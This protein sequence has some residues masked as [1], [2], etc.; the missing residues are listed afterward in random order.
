MSAGARGG[1]AAAWWAVARREWRMVVSSPAAWVAMA[2]FALPPGIAFAVFCVRPGAPASLRLPLQAA[3]WALFVAAPVLGMRTVVEERRAGTWDPLLAS[4]A[5]PATI[6]LGKLAALAGLVALF[7]LPLLAEFGLLSLVAAPDAAE[8]ACGLLGVMLAG[9]AI[10]ASALWMS[11]LAPSAVSAYVLTVTLWS[12]WAAA[13]RAI[14]QLLP[15]P[16]SASGFS[17]DPLRRVDDFLAGLLDLGAVAFFA[18]ATAAAAVGAVDAVRDQLRPGP[19][20][21]RLLPRTAWVAGVACALGAAAWIANAPP[22]RAQVDLT[23]TRSWT[24]SRETVEMVARLP[25]DWSVEALVGAGHVDPV[26]LRQLDEVL[27]RLDGLP[28][29]D[30]VLRARRIDPTDPAGAADFERSLE[31]AEAADGEPLTRARRETDAGLKSLQAL[32]AFSRREVGAVTLALGS[33]PAGGADPAPGGWTPEDR[34]WLEQWRASL[35][36]LSTEGAALVD[37]IRTR[38][39]STPE[40]P[41]GDPAGAAAQ[42]AESLRAWTDQLAGAEKQ[43]RERRRGAAP[44]AMGAE[45]LRA[46]PAR[47]LEMAS[48][49]RQ[50]QDALAQ[51]PPLGVAEVAAALRGG[52]ALVVT[53]PAGVA[54]VPGWQVLP[55]GGDGGQGGGVAFDRR[56]RGEQVIA[57]ALRSIAKGEMPEVVVVHGEGRSLLKATGD[58]AD[59]SAMADAL[60]AARF[61]VREWQPGR[62]PRPLPPAGRGQ[63][64]VVLPPLARSDAEADAAERRMLAA[65][66]RLVEEGA[67]ML[68]ALPPSALPLL[69]RSDPWAELASRLGVQAASAASL[70]EVVPVSEREREVRSWFEVSP[71]GPHPVGA[72]AEGLAAIVSSPIPLQAADGAAARVEPILQVEP[73]ENRWREDDWRRGGRQ[74]REAPAEKRIRAA[75]P[76][77]MAVQGSGRRAVVSG[78]AG[79]MLSGLADMT[80]SLGGERVFL[81]YPGNREVLVSAVGWLAGR[82]DALRSG[83]GREVPRVPALQPAARWSLAL[84]AALGIPLILVLTGAGLRA[85]RGSG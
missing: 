14:P 1:Q 58:R 16:W 69:G 63:V 62:E 28:T 41:L 83:S 31:R 61:Q 34:A 25:G 2:A 55:A 32:V 18:A 37:A 24:L 78:G 71:Q 30:G 44:S 17:L 45:Y 59:L 81:R 48:L 52:D 77:L 10:M 80:A 82:D 7:S 4:P 84:A 38:I 8:F 20:R 33:E 19:A 29:R 42:L 70:L 39:R 74:V 3:A 64:F 40:R 13:S 60:R 36:K 15:A 11:S 57:S 72:A 46:A 6:V 21:P 26:A 75:V 76:V 53:G 22:L 35:G 54:A 56:F 73:A 68:L 12:A 67:P 49:L 85:I 5:S 9:T 65:V 47:I 79:W 23:R 27:A 50:R 51:L 43:L 66:E